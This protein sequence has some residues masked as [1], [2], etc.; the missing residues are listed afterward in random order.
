MGQFL[1]ARDVEAAVKGGSVFAAGG[2]GFADPGRMLA[3][4]PSMTAVPN[5]SGSTSASRWR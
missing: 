5:S 1:G 2:G 3:R 4:P